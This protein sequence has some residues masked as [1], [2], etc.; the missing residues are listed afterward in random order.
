MLGPHA[1]KVETLWI[2]L[3]TEL[4]KQWFVDAVSR[5]SW[6]VYLSS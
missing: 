1:D 6:E 4:S 3:P 5:P 2:D